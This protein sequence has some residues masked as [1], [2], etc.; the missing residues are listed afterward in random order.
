MIDSV[1]TDAGDVSPDLKK[2]RRQKAATTAPARIDRLPPHSIEA[3]QGVLGCVLLSPGDCLGVCIEKFKSGAELFYDLRHRH[4]YELLVEMY[5]QQEAIDLLTVQQ[6]LKDR[7]QLEAVGGLAYLSSLPDAVPSAANLSYYADIVWE[8]HLLR[9]MIQTCTEVVGRV[10]EHEGEVDALLDEVERDI[11]HISESRVESSTNTIK[12]L[13]HTAITTIEN[14]HQRQGML[15]GVGTGFLDLDKMTSGF[16]EGEMIVIAARPSMGKTSL[17]MNIA[18]HVAIELRLPVGVF[19]LEMTANSLVL[20]M[21]CSRSRVNL[22][23]VRDG[24]LAEREFP[25]LTGPPGKPST[26]PL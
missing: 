18:E 6:R 8:K 9:K 14:F 4:I 2:T 7:N 24:F 1:E 17:A 15:T 13:V 10:Y 19:S 21:L 16:H 25:K 23:N 3:E 5:A 12:E 11:L 22:R 26:E 20:R